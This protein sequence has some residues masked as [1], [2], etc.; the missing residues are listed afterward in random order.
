MAPMVEQSLEG[1]SENLHLTC[2]SVL[3]WG[4]ET[5]NGPDA[6]LLVYMWM[7]NIP[8]EQRGHPARLS[9]PQVYEC[10]S[11]WVNVKPVV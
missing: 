5:Q 3:E 1:R 4:T 7:V 6:A 2:Q 10:V 8:D 9:P 11:E